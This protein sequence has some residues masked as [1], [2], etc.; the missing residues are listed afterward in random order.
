M[1]AQQ[2]E[3]IRIVSEWGFKLTLVAFSYLAWDSYQDLK[4]GMDA[5]RGDLHGID[6]RLIRVETK[7]EK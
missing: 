6:G 5:M 4:K 3:V 1:S 7:L 2:K